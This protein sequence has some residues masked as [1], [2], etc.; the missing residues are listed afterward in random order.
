MDLLQRAIGVVRAS[1]EGYQ[2]KLIMKLL[3]RALQVR[4]HVGQPPLA[5]ATCESFLQGIPSVLQ[6][7]SGLSFGVRT[8]WGWVQ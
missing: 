1:T 4:R 6:A 5:S 7:A 3:L 2:N 8:T